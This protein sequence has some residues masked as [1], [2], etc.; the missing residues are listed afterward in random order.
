MVQILAGKGA[1]CQGLALYGLY[2]GFYADRFRVTR[3]RF[4]HLEGY[5]RYGDGDPKAK[6]Q[7]GRSLAAGVSGKAH[8]FKGVGGQDTLGEL[9]QTLERADLLDLTTRTLGQ[10]SKPLSELQQ[11]NLPSSLGLPFGFPYSF[12]SG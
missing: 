4:R 3:G 6:T 9:G 10:R 7:G 2:G 5:R 8:L 11:K 1:V 12:S